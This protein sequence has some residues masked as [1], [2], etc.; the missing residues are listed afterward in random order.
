MAI[1]NLGNKVQVLDAGGRTIENGVI[2]G[3][4]KE[5]GVALSY[6]S[7]DKAQRVADILDGAPPT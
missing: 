4:Y 5:I 3:T 2:S 6:D 1:E 7:K